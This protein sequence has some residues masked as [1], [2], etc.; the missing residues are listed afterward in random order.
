MPLQ[1]ARKKANPNVKIIATAKVARFF[2]YYLLWNTRR[3]HFPY[4][5]ACEF[6]DE[7]LPKGDGDDDV[8]ARFRT[9]ADASMMLDLMGPH[10]QEEK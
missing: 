6:S 4:S 3:E 2:T 5:L 1:P 10:R 9:K 7:P 8:F